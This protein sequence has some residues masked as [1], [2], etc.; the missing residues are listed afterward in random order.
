MFETPQPTRTLRVLVGGLVFAMGAQAV[1]FFFGSIAW[2]VRDSLGVGVTDLIPMVLA[3]F[4]VGALIPGLSRWLT[5]RGAMWVGSLVLVAARVVNQLSA[6]PAV[7]AWSA[8]VG[9]AAF[10]GLLP[11]LLSMGRSALVGG[12]LLGLALDSAIKGMGLSLDLGY[13]EG[14]GPIVIVLA[15][16]LVTLFLL[17]LSPR[18]D[19]RGVSWGSGWG[20]VGVGPLLFAEFLVLQNQGWTSEVAGMSGPQAQLRIALLN[21]VALVVLAWL[22][23]SRPAALVALV[24]V[25]GTLMVAEGDPLLFNLMSLAA[26][27]SAAL[28]WS[29]LVGEPEQ[30]GIGASTAYLLAGMILFAAVGLLYYLPLDLRLGYTQEHARLA[31]AGILAVLGLGSLVSVA[32]IRPGVSGQAWAFAALFSVLPLLGFF[33]TGSETRPAR[34]AGGVVRVMTYNIHSGYDATGRFDIE[35]I[36][37]VIDDSGADVVGLQEV[38]RGL[39]ISGVTDGLTLLQAR[40]G[41]EHAAFF[42]TTDPAWGNAVLSRF[43]IDNVD[44]Q[45][46]PLVGTPM[47]RGYLGA[48]IELP[49]GLLLFISTHLQHINE[50]SV[51]DADPEADLYPVHRSQM[52][53][54]VSAW[55]GV[56]PAVLVGDFNARPEWAQID[57]L[58]SAGWV[59]SW[60]ESGAGEGL[61]A[62]AAD[63]R[64]R[65]D[66]VFHTP[67]IEAVDAG[68]I[69]SQASDHFPVVVDLSIP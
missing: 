10:V 2:Y 19:R 21:V 20:L 17:F 29:A 43:P 66:Y 53:A 40:L 54:I 16:G 59:D 58:L 31:G 65:I 67:D 26:V 60:P 38:P 61:T 45:H 18:V 34:S 62:N 41:F 52:G 63:P 11:L 56:E 36:A 57:E 50:P 25:V 55:G 23:H 4:L 47:R 22:E 5:I 64:Y 1:R 28:V 6:D 37:R 33:L 12:L 49:D 30:G 68:V 13:Q 69:R 32:A 27:P 3:P 24:A 9:V 8:G 46:L 42:G 7:E 39:L 48:T 15:L 51:H 35:E 44:T 14:L